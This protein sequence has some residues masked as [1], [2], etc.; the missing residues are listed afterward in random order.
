MQRRD[1]SSGGKRHEFIQVDAIEKI[2]QGKL[3]CFGEEIC[4]GGTGEQTAVWRYGGGISLVVAD[5]YDTESGDCFSGFCGVRREWKIIFP[6]ALL[7]RVI[8]F[9]ISDGI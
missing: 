2:S 1:R 6:V 7:F 8:E 5:L 4:A 3:A 9:Y